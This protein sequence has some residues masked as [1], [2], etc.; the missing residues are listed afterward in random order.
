MQSQRIQPIGQLNQVSWFPF[1]D[2]PVLSGKWYLP[3]LSDPV[4]LFPE[5]APDRKWHLFA[6]SWMGIHH[7]V[8]NSGI[9][10][11]SVKLIQVRGQSPFLHKEKGVFYLLYER[12]GSS[13]PFVEKL[14]KVSRKNLITASHIEMRSSND[15]IVWSEP[16][17]LLDSRDIP[18]AGDYLRKPC[19]THPQV[20]AVDGGYRLYFGASTVRLKDSGHVCGRYLLSSFSKNLA[21]P[22]ELDPP[23]TMM[24]PIP[25]D[26]WRSLGCGRLSIVK[27]VEGYAAL[28]TGVFWDSANK[29]TASAITL[30]FSAD[31]LNWKLSNQPVVLVPADRGWASQY[32]TAC[33]IR[34]KI[35]EGCWYCY[36][37]AT[38]ER[39]F[40]FERESIGLLIAKDP[41][42]RKPADSDGN[43]FKPI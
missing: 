20:L 6:H 22:F 9:L 25:N 15:L 35:D 43:L 5:E 28:Q 12:H 27:G 23:G 2:E 38:G 40:G 33:D 13:I 3:K 16:R 37:S 21:G 8:S 39:R 32:I 24:E 36:F 26:S 7:F 17:I 1:S 31:G 18:H 29:R 34:Y 14:N 41:A 4:F 19:L 10:W 42:L 30:L 11:E